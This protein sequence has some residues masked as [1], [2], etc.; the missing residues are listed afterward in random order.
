LRRECDP[1]RAWI[2]EFMHQAAAPRVC[3]GLRLI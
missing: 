3:E 1:Q 2:Q